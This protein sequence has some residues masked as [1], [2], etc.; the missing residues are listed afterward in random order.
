VPDLKVPIGLY[1]AQN[2]NIVL[3]NESIYLHLADK[4]EEKA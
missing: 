2:V 1:G 4:N 3:L